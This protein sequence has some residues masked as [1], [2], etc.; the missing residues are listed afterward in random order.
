MSTVFS[1]TPTSLGLTPAAGAARR[2]QRPDG[3]RSLAALLLTAAVAA[4]VVV[5]D[6]LIDTW[7]DGHL[8]L[9]WVALWVLMFA[10]SALMAGSA[11]RM[12]RSTMNALDGWSRSLAESRAEA[13]LWELARRDPRLKAELVR[14][15]A[16]VALTRPTV[17]A[18]DFSLALAPMGLE[19]DMASPALLRRH[20]Q[21]AMQRHAGYL[22]YI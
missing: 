21:R 20:A 22:P 12:A 18:D 6:Q 17:A 7:V 8:F 16:A 15:R 5:A 1:P 4:L 14:Q 9:G 11:R 10:G 13:R 3:A 2:V 19:A